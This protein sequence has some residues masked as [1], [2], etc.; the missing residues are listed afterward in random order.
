MG[1]RVTQ[2]KVVKLKR[3][4]RGLP[5]K[6]SAE[7]ISVSTQGVAKHITKE[8]NDRAK[9]GEPSV[10]MRGTTSYQEAELR[11][12]NAYIQAMWPE[13]CVVPISGEMGKA[14]EPRRLVKKLADKIFHDLPPEKN[15]VLSKSAFHVERMHWN[16]RLYYVVFT[17]YLHGTVSKSIP[18]GSRK[19]LM[20]ARARG[21]RRWHT[22]VSLDTDEP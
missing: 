13:H 10:F 20:L 1:N 6:Y 11:A 16:D 4:K 22:S 5:K 9:S 17:D 2:V 18:F 21:I 14:N 8:A 12:R 19:Q 3:W 7:Y 15:I